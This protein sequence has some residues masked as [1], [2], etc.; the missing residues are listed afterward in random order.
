MSRLVVYSSRLPTKSHLRLLRIGHHLSQTIKKS[1]T[2]K[3]AAKP[4]GFK[5]T[6]HHTG[7]T[8]SF[9][10]SQRWGTSYMYYVSCV[11]TTIFLSENYKICLYN[12]YVQKRYMYT[13]T[14]MHMFL[15]FTT[16]IRFFLLFIQGNRI[17]YL[18]GRTSFCKDKLHHFKACLTPP[19][20][21]PLDSCDES[22]SKCRRMVSSNVLSQ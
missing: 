18:T 2:K 17:T 11:H 4:V 9:W 1:P 21:C 15:R 20:Y 6:T 16:E 8:T 7:P 19:F 10:N 12:K 14:N 5:E 13:H 3:T 22:R